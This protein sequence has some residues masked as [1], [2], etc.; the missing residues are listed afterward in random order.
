[1]IRRRELKRETVDL[2]VVDETGRRWLRPAGFTL[3]VGDVVAPAQR[4][5][6]LGGPQQLLE[7]LSGV[8]AP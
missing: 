1:M 5:V 6:K 3:R 2:S 4:P 7:D 8:F